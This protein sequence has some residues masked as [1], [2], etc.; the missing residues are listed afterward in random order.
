MILRDEQLRTGAEVGVQLGTFSLHLLKNWSNC[1]EFHAIDLWAHQEHY[2]DPANSPQSVQEEAFQTA[3]KNLENFNHIIRYHRNFSHLAAK[4]IK[5]ESLDFIYLDARHD[6]VGVAEDLQSYWPKLK[7]GGIMAGHDYLDL[8]E[9]RTIDPEQDWGVDAR[10]I[11]RTDNKAVKSAVNE[12]ARE[13]NRQ[14]LQTIRDTWPSW[15]MRK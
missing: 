1:V 12:F 11:K 15:Y 2:Q 8:D 14:V 9:Q 13:K 5:N 7:P 3:K 6:Y 4:E 10:G